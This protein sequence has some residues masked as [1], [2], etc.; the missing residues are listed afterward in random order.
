MR[1]RPGEGGGSIVDIHVEM[2]FKGAARL[3]GRVVMRFYGGGVATYRKWFMRTLD[4]LERELHV[5]HS[6]PRRS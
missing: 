2:G 5:T 1:V 6:A 3:L 4:V